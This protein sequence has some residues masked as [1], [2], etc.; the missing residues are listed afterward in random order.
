MD[1]GVKLEDCT[2]NLHGYKLTAWFTR[3]QS[4][5]NVAILLKDNKD[6]QLYAKASTN[7]EE[8]LPDDQ[9]CIKTWS[10]NQ[11]MDEA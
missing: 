2:V 4:N 7:I 11:G 1:N 8:S 5:K 3:Y 10:E 9:V 6:G